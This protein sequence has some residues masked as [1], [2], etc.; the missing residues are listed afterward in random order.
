MVVSDMDRFEIHTNFTSTAK[1]VHLFDLAG[2]AVPANLDILRRV[3]TDPDS[4]KP[5]IT[6][7]AITVEAAD[8]FAKLADG[9]RAKGIE[10]LRAA[11]FLMKLMFCMFGEDTM[12][13]PPGL[14]G[15]LLDTGK[16]NRAMLP[17]LLQTLFEA[18]AKGG[19]YG[20]DVILSCERARA[21]NQHL[22]PRACP[23][24]DLDR[25]PAMDALQR[26]QDARPS[27]FDPDRHDKADGRDSGPFRPRASQGA[28]MA[29]GGVH[30]G[31]PA[32]LG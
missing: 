8:R 20:S 29:G 15:K 19:V 21:G 26:L 12:L 14:F 6:S 13:L 5:G 30:R 18:M 31:E 9:M 17:R 24:R 32:V 1:H 10:P 7:E 2:L 27:G 4:L 3:F 23:S 25:L 28:G 11:H 16:A 22:R